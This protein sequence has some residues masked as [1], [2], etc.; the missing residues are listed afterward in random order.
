MPNIIIKTFKAFPQFKRRFESFLPDNAFKE[1]CENECWEW[2]GIIGCSIRDSGYG[3]IMWGNKR[4]RAYRISYFLYKGEI[5]RDKVVMHTC[6]NP[7]CVNPKHLILGTHSDNMADMIR[8]ERRTTKLNAE[9]VKVIKWMLKYKN[10]RG[11]AKKLA[12]LYKTDRKHI[13]ALKND[14]IWNWVKV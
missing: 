8:K 4:Y 1:G 10:R 2:Q 14:H 6:D 3:S 9:A 5:P 13:S 12:E 7:R 11:L